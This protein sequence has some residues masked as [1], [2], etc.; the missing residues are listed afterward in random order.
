[1]Y[2][3]VLYGSENKLRL[4]PY[5]ALTGWFFNR[6]GVCLLRGTNWVYV[7]NTG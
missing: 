4:F 5:T 2:L 1:M 6:E 7:Y 3:R